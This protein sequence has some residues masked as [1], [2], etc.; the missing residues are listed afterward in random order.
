[1]TLFYDHEGNDSMIE[2]IYDEMTFWRLIWR[3]EYVWYKMWSWKKL[4][5]MKTIAI[6]RNYVWFM[7][8]MW[9]IMEGNICEMI[10]P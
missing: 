3:E 10:W 8:C 9:Y 1:V 7:K 6:R 2:E 5:R 4:W